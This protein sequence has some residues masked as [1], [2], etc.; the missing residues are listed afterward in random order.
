MVG[1]TI[2][3]SPSDFPDKYVARAWRTTARRVFFYARPLAVVDTLD[4]ARAAVAL[5]HAGLRNVGREAE[6]D[7]VIV[8]SYR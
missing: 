1:V 4:E 6:D 3:R 5:R 2:Y 8:E 7:P